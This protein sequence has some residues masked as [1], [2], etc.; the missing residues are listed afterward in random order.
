MK[1][2]RLSALCTG[3]LYPQKMFLVL[4]SVRGWVDPRVIVRPEGLCW[5]KIP[6]TP[7]GIEPATFRFV[8]Q[9]LNQLR[10][11]VSPC[12]RGAVNNQRHI[13]V[14]FPP[15]IKARYPT[16]RKLSEP[17]GSSEQE[18]RRHLLPHKSSNPETSRPKRVSRCTA[19]DSTG[20]GGGGGVNVTYLY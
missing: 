15:G 12:V 20:R 7:S 13:P 9:C 1:V 16:Y 2:V 14:A 6:V 5:W 11:R 8:V 17:Q 4:I 19:C 10:H 3:R 18:W